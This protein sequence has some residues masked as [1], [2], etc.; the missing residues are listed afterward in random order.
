MTHHGSGSRSAHALVTAV[1]EACLRGVGASIDA[2]TGLPDRA[3]LRRRLHE[4]LQ[5]VSAHGAQLALLV[6]DLDQ[7]DD[8]NEAFG[9]AAADGLLR[10]VGERLRGLAGRSGALVARVGGDG[11][12]IVLP[13]TGRRGAE[14]AARALGRLLERPFV[15][16][17]H[18]VVASATTG[19]ALSR[20]HGVDADV[21]VR[22]ATTAMQTAKRGGAAHTVYA[23]AHERHRARFLL[24]NELRR[25]L[26]GEELFLQYQP[27]IGLLHGDVV[28]VEAL[29]RW[30]HPSRG[31]LGPGEFVPLAER[32][33]LGGPLRRWVV[34][35]A[36]GAARRWADD[37]WPVPVAVNLAPEDLLDEGLVPEV[38]RAL[39][40]A[41][42]PGSRLAVE[43][44]ERSLISEPDRVARTFARLRTLGVR[45]LVDD[46]GSGYSSLGYL[47]RL[48][49]DGLKIDRAFVAAAG[50]ARGGAVMRSIVSLGEALDLGVVAEGVESAAQLAA[51]RAAGCRAAQGY[52]LGRPARGRT[53]EDQRRGPVPF[54]TSVPLWPSPPLSA[55]G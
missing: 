31:V 47:H 14:R 32:S 27:V 8:V 4:E 17:G 23:P 37:G 11:F 18:P 38:A 50:D 46:F 51:L 5:R 24:V 10:A 35:T 33:R 30:Q 48:P 16:E 15:V 25:A 6:A 22:R 44:T 39:S 3:A 29:A 12:A 7:F 26:E 55:A 28:S 2:L 49:V 36:L 45:V 53:F 52:Y 20:E 13:R 19:I 1:A 42:L 9:Y 43:V 21:L 34:M 54:A 41:R 40:Q